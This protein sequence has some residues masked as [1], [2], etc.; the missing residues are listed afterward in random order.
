M[1]SK[2]DWLWDKRITAHKAKGILSNPKDKHFLSL[3][4][5]LLARKNSPQEVLGEYLSP[6]NFLFNWQKIKKQMRRDIWNNP[7]IE[8]WQAVYEKVRE[9]YKKKGILPVRESAIPKPRDELCKII[10]D[11]IK[12]ARKQK[13]LTQAELAKRLGV[14]QQ[15]VSR[16]EK[17]KE[18]V[19]LVTLK[20]I[21]S[22]LGGQLY[23]DIL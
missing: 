2:E 1:N 5:T 14:S 15:M 18:N 8:F 19:S 23:V 4:S 10:A 9:K 22:S 12:S 17:G 21:V 7:R 13:G 11:K 6:L 16:I 3:A 20:N